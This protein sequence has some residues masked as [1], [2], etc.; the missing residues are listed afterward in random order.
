MTSTS[1]QFDDATLEAAAKQAQESNYE[2]A[3]DISAAPPASESTTPTVT[4]PTVAESPVNTQSAPPP[5][6]AT[7]PVDATMPLPQSAPE[8]QRVGFL[9]VIRMFIVALFFGVV[10][11]FVFQNLEQVTVN[12]AQWSFK[13]PLAA[14]IGGVAVVGN[15]IGSLLMLGRRRKK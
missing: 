10:A 1:D 15:L 11:M 5:A 3:D 9:Q 6:A 7:R 2:V 8:P 13:L 12:F 4:V 14:L